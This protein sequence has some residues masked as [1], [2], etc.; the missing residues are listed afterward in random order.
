MARDSESHPLSEQ[1]QR[2]R[3]EAKELRAENERLRGL[4][5]MPEPTLVAEAPPAYTLFP[6]AGPL[7]VVDDSSPIRERVHL[8]RTLLRGREDVYALR[9][10]SA[11]TGKVGYSPAVA[12]GWSDPKKKTPR[13]YLPLTDDVIEEHLAG[14]QTIGVY[15]L[16]QH[17]TC[18]FLACDFDGT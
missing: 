14:H 13:D 16:L 17:D 8:I 1:L 7:P 9:W 6:L 15:P 2:V 4:L 18:F 11:R 3:D 12:G 5:G 10:T